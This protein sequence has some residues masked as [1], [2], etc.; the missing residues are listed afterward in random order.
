MGK[1]LCR[2]ASAERRKRDA[3]LKLYICLS[4]GQHSSSYLY[5]KEEEGRIRRRKRRRRRERKRKYKSGQTCWKRRKRRKKVKRLSLSLPPLSQEG[6]YL[7]LRRP[8]QREEGGREEGGSLGRLSHRR[9]EEG[10][11]LSLWRRKERGYASF[12]LSLIGGGGLNDIH[13]IIICHHEEE[14]KSSS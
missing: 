5:R 11:L 8:S 14:R 9:K 12:S 4:P 7:S 2:Y 10:A 3:S 13:L 6:K 1:H